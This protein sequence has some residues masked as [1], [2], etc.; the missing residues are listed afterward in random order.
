M[1]LPVI[2]QGP[3]R[4]PR[5]LGNVE[6]VRF[7]EGFYPE[8]EDPLDRF[9]WMSPR[10]VLGVDPA[11]DER[12]LELQVASEYGD[13]SQQLT[14][15][16]GERE[17]RLDLPHQWNLLSVPISP[18]TERITLETN[19]IFP[20]A[21]YPGDG[22]ELSIRVKDAY[23]HTDASRHRSVQRQWNNKVLNLREMLEGKLVL[24]STP[25]RLGIDLHGHCNVK[26]PCVY[27]FWDEAKET[28][29]G[30]TDKP[31]TL[32]T[33]EEYGPFFD[34]AADLQNCSVGEPFMMRQ[35][36]ELLDAFG[37]Q[38]KFLEMSTNG[39]ILTERNVQKLLGR[40][41]HLYVSLDAA[42]AETY[43]TLRNDRFER[44]LMN[45]RRL[46]DA[47]DLHH[48][49]LPRVFLVFMPMRANLDELEAFVKLCRDVKADQL[50]L[51]PLNTT[52]GSQL[53]WDRSGYHFDYEREILPFPELVRTSG[54]AAALCERYGVELVDQLDFGGELEGL[55][56]EQYREGRSEASREAS[57]PERPAGAVPPERPAAP[58]FSELPVAAKPPSAAEP[59]GPPPPLGV[60]KWPI[61][62]E[63]WSN[64]YI[65]RRGVL[66]CSYGYKAI[67]DMDDYRDAWNSELLQEI[68][69]KLREGEL[70]PYCISSRACP[71]LRKWESAQRLTLRQQ[72]W[73]WL[74]RR[75]MSLNKWTGGV[76][77][78]L[79]RGVRWGLARVGV[80][81][82]GRSR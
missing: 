67:A 41:I 17:E 63:P 55:F 5:F 18:A 57:E 56:E 4:E 61:C 6:A 40:N 16:Q 81:T 28:E 25:S 23:L 69:A 43:R 24:E 70:H 32:E 62:T 3:S 72:G 60:E 35:L 45:L 7:E 15:R 13:L 9:R 48:T 8:E 44:I 74:W 52:L 14:F 2:Q 12:F 47:K 75:W 46:A 71:I 1:E 36:D 59:E 37:E 39:Q 53:V 54:R 38:G 26:P 50:V 22:R 80:S 21:H 31:F 51:R 33:L 29:G 11:S 42:T 66:P 65:L 68:R 27:C 82:S 79:L 73:L 19:K 58:A 49:K 76:P 34:N 10:G 20:K 78:T 30:N 77:R 64:L